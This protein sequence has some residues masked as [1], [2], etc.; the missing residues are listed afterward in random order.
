MMDPLLQKELDEL[1]QAAKDLHEGVKEMKRNLGLYRWIK[2]TPEELITD[3]YTWGK[4]YAW[5]PVKDVHG[6]WHWLKDIY[7]IPGNT[8]MDYD[9]WRWYHYGTVFDVI[10]TT[11]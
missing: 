8:Y 11:K 5:K 3:G 6:K 4:W 1:H 10:R 7:R 2:P 9:D